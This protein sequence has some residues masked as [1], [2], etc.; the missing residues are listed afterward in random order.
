MFDNIPYIILNKSYEIIDVHNEIKETYPGLL[1]DDF[2]RNLL[3][4]YDFDYFSQP[5]EFDCG[6]T[7]ISNIRLLFVKENDMLK[8]IPI[9]SRVYGLQRQR[10]L[11]F[12]LREPIS[13]I[14]AMLPVI[15]DN[16]NKEEDDKAV[17]N[18]ETLNIQSY[19]L[20]KNVNNISLVARIMSGDIPAYETVNLSS[21]LNTIISSVNIVYDRINVNASIEN[22]I[23]IGVNKSFITN[24]IL[25]LISNSINFRNDDD[26]KIEINLKKDGKSIVFS[27]AD[28][29]KGIKDELLPFVFKPYFS[30][31]PFNDNAPDP[32][33]GLGLF[34]AKTAFNSAGGK[35]MTISSFGNGVKYVVTL[36]SVED[37]GHLLESSTREFLLDRYSELYIQLCES[38]QLPPLK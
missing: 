33:L 10:N 18:L 16:I 31:D 32:S 1:V 38:C 4:G 2:F 20:L 37:D 7:D 36:P 17:S 30:K 24:A 34:I 11:H 9:K 19:R 28:N 8:C 23:Y 35:M 26:V 15:A 29:S 12:R 3:D 27:Y 21:I 25:N 14:F 5:V 6:M 22:D 13:S